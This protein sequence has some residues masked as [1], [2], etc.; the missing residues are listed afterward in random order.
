[1]YKL[2]DVGFVEVNVEHL[3]DPAMCNLQW[4]IYNIWWGARSWLQCALYNVWCARSWQ[5]CTM[6]NVQDIDAHCHQWQCAIIDVQG[7]STTMLDDWC[8]DGN[9]QWLMFNNGTSSGTQ[10]SSSHCFGRLVSN[11]RLGLPRLGLAG[12]SS[13]QEC[14]ILDTW[15]AT[16]AQ[17]TAWLWDS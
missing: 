15:S 16:W 12:H 1:M 5:Q 14:Q 8:A 6:T 3:S 13:L 7:T 17:V 4:A 11:C 9:V 10:F 2:C